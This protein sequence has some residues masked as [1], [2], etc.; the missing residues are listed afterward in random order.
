LT[1]IV[2]GGGAAG[3]FAAI[4]AAGENPAQK[5]MLLE[6]TRRPLAKVRISGGGRC[7]VTHH[8]FDARELAQNYP[9]GGKELLGPFS[10]FQPKDTVRWFS[11]RGVELKA[12]A[13]GRM[14]PTTDSSETVI[15]CLEAARHASG[16]GLRLGAILRA[17]ARTPEG[18][19]L[20]LQT[21]EVVA[22]QRLLLATGGAPQGYELARGLGHAI[23]PL[24]PS[25]FTFNATDPRLDGLSGVAFPRTALALR[26]DGD[27]AVFHREG[28]LL[29][30]HWGLSGPAVL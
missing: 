12:E 3:F 16:A 17:V 11:E 28:P 9:R 5:V 18:F 7:N 25:L 15:N 8:C 24:A 13:D 30:T 27:K 19:A 22:A 21:G 1:A 14:F 23:E 29:I 4:R 26:A 2:V 10:R 6:G 20:T